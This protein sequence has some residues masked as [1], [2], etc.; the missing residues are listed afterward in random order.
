MMLPLSIPDH[1]FKQYDNLIKEFLW[2]GRKPR[3]KLSK[4]FAPKDKGGLSLPDV[5]L[6]NLNFEMAKIAKHWSG[7]VSDLNWVTIEQT[8]A[9]P[10]H[11]IQVLS[12]QV[13]GLVEYRNPVI[14]HSREVWDRQP[15]SSLWLNPELKIGKCTVFW[16]KCVENGIHTINDLYNEVILKSFA[17]LAQEYN[18]QEKG[19]FWKYLQVRHCIV[20]KKIS[21]L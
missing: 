13:T 4:L 9:T 14:K 5:R 17:E 1:I 18:L 21:Q 8:L 3:F 2:A 19:D 12:Q 10:F 15:Y 16:K 11:P 7:M 6:Y 20:T